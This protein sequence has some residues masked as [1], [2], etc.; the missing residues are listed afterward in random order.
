MSENRKI[1]FTT[2]KG[3]FI[4]E[5][6]EDKAPKTTKNFIELDPY[7]TRHFVRTQLERLG[8]NIVLINGVIGHE[9]NR[10]EALGKFSSLSKAL[11]YAEETV[12]VNL[13]N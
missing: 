1:R 13:V 10:Q 11:S 3:E 6:F 4:V 12:Q 9:K 7:W 5:M 8:V 2:N